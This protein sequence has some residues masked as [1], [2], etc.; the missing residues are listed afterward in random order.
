MVANMTFSILAYDEKTGVL[1]AAAATGSLCVGGW[2]LR[3]SLDGGLVASQG[4]APSTLWRDE[5]LRL[6]AEG[7]TAENA[8]KS[9]TERDRGRAHRQLIALDRDGNTAGFTGIE[10]VTWAGHIAQAGL[11]AAGN[12]I[13]GNAVLDALKTAFTSSTAGMAD[14]LVAALMAA[15]RA[16][17]DSR[18]LQSAALLVLSPDASPL[19]LRIDCHATPLVALRD[20]LTQTRTRPY[21][22]WLDEVPVMSDPMRA[23]QSTAET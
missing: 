17:S 23:P 12:M 8:V 20:L 16:G 1:G 10:S 7:M 2:V 5:T 22:D 19:D 18:G 6:M 4:T 3:G 14:R 15:E 13:A 11:A 21:A 9:V